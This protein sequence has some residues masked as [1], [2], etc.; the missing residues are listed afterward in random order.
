MPH[1]STSNSPTSYFFL[2]TLLSTIPSTTR[3]HDKLS[4]PAAAKVT[5][6]VTGVVLIL[7]SFV[8]LV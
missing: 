4:I 1:T 3:T 8:R 7:L 2:H 5:P 6:M